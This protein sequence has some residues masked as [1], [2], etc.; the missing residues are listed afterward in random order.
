[1]RHALYWLD[2]R[3][4]RPLTTR[5]TLA[6]VAIVVVAGLITTL[7]VNEVLARSLSQELEKSGEAVTLALGENIANALVEGNLATVRETL[8]SAVAN[9]PDIV[10]AYAFR[11]GAPVVHTFS[12]GFPADLLSLSPATGRPG[13]GVLLRSEHGLI[14]HFAYRPLPGL[15]TEVHVG[16]SQARIAAE[17][18]RITTFVV[19]LTAGG[20]LAAAVAAY[21]FSYL[22][23]RPLVTLTQ[24]ARRLGQGRLE[25]RLE[26]PPGDEVGDLAQAFNQMA[27]GI[28]QA[29][30]KL[31]VSETGYRD[32]LTAAGAVGEGIA[33]ICDEAP[34]EGTLLFVNNTFAE[35]AGFKPAELIGANVGSV[36]HPD[37]LVAAHQIWSQ[38]RANSSPHVSGELELLNRH[39]RRHVLETAGTRL[40][41]QGKHALAWFTRDVS[42]RRARE[43]ETARRNRELTALNAV[44]AAVSRLL[45]PEELLERAL[46]QALA[47]LALETGWVFVLDEDGRARLAAQCGLPPEMPPP[48]FPDCPCGQAVTEGRALVS[49]GRLAGCPARQA[50]PGLPY[51]AT[52]PLRARGRTVGALSV[53]AADAAHFRT[54]EID[55]LAAIG[56]QMG[57]ALENARLWEQLR[58][59]EQLRGELLARIIHAQEEERQRIARELHDATGQSL[60]ALVIGLN[61]VTTALERSPDSVPALLE[62]LKV[63][64]SDTVRELQSIIYDLRPALLDDLGL[65]PVLRWYA[66]ERLEAQGTCVTLTVDG[67]SGRL[68]AEVETALFRIG[69]EAITNISRHAGARHVTIQV[70]FEP[71]HVSIEVSDDGLGFAVAGALDRSQQ[72]PGLGLLGIRERANLL[73]GRLSIESEPGAGTRLHVLLPLEGVMR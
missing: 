63:S 49:D 28:E 50:H 51:H 12:N 70:R 8:G 29:I 23:T 40:D 65:I 22:A 38:I 52:V 26:L 64:A 44:A 57:V 48:A 59:K 13:P 71:R 10:Y 66:R 27:D 58:R 39:G 73:G 9:N 6:T 43:E 67:E 5:V 32:L 1:M 60:N 45:A 46:E 61:A 15:P 18:A 21:L 41:Y 53:L 42:E 33:L 19:L 35:L 4:P 55:L 7:V 37:S 68:P 16:F 14:R 3:L 54:S 36:L 72:R 2:R 56:Q 69:Q 11:P 17:Q 47:A 31:R 30:H 24:H 20:C 25:E 62:R 34:G